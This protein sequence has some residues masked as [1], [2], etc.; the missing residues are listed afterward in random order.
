MKAN[1]ETTNTGAVKL[2]PRQ[3]HGFWGRRI[4]RISHVPGYVPEPEPRPVCKQ[5]DRCDGCPYP[6]HGFLCWGNESDCMRT[7][8][9][10]IRE[11][12][13]QNDDSI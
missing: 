4:F 2:S 1:G 10:K 11:R 12:E 6:G 7:R 5:F 9:K 3:W 13:R 8:I